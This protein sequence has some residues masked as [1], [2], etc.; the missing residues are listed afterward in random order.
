MIERIL[1]VFGKE[2]IDNLR[3]RRSVLLAL[4]YPFIGPVMIGLL[5]VFVGAMITALPKA[6]FT[7][8][9]EGAQHAP[10]LIAFLENHRTL[11]VPAPEDPAYAVRTG[12]HDTALIIP[13]G[14]GKRI[15]GEGTASVQLVVDGSRLAGVV[16][17]S[18]THGLLRDYNKSIGAERLRARGLDP[19]ITNPLVVKYIN[20]SVG[21]NLTGFFLNMMPPFIIFTIFVGGVYLAI[22]TTSGERERGSLEPLLANPIARW[23]LMAGKVCAALVFTAMALIVQLI[24]FEAMFEMISEGGF[25]LRVRPGI[26]VFVSVFLVCAPLMLFAVGIQMIIATVTHSFKETQ[27]YLGLLPIVPALPGVVLVFVAVKAHT[28]MMAIPTFGQIV[29]IGQIVRG[30]IVKPVDVAVASTVTAAA[31]L[32][33]LA[34]ASRLYQR[35]ALVLGG[36]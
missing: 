34:I 11:V 5:V 32:A 19:G 8:P 14:Y 26:L 12:Q 20:V 7:L 17:M 4:L 9:V 1:V 16:A 33:L 3:D 27:T 23:E 35:D 28:W 21:R 25:G 18:R 15:A 24:T 30:E 13:E 36:N 29:L 2:V 22:D 6:T 31:A 10:R